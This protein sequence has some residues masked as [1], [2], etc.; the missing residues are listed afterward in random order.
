M[1]PT[2]H[3]AYEPKLHVDGGTVVSSLQIVCAW[4]QQ[5]LGW[6]CV[7]PPT[8]FPISYSICSCCYIAVARELKPLTTGAASPGLPPT[9]AHPRARP[10]GRGPLA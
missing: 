2:A 1:E 7:Q 4:C 5:P 3:T 9:D 10:A 6:H 8:P